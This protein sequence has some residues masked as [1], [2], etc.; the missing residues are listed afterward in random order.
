MF[1]VLFLTKGCYWIHTHSIA[2]LGYFLLLFLP[3]LIYSK[4]SFWEVLSLLSE[5][6]LWLCPAASWYCAEQAVAESLLFLTAPLKA[7]NVSEGLA[8]PWTEG[9][10]NDWTGCGRETLSRFNT[11]L[12]KYLNQRTGNGIIGWPKVLYRTPLFVQSGIVVQLK[13]LT[14]HSPAMERWHWQPQWVIKC[15]LLLH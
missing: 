5:E 11:G 14:T 15:Y 1:S 6:K 12:P 8:E 4:H 9:S 13:L 2:H 7:W 10:G 3:F